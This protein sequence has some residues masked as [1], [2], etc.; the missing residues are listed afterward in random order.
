MTFGVLYTH[1]NSYPFRRMLNVMKEYIL[2][3]LKLYQVYLL[4]KPNQTAIENSKD[5]DNSK[6]T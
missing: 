3:F 5:T 4:A 1:G 6:W 2:S